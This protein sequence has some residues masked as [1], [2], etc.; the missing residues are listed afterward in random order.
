M[1]LHKRLIQTVIIF[2][3]TTIALCF[4]AF[5]MPGL[6]ITSIPAA[7][8][9]TLVLVLVESAYWWLFISFFSRMPVWLYPIVTF[10]LTGIAVYVAGNFVPGITIDDIWTGI[11]IALW[12]TVISAVLAGLFSLDADASFDRNVTR[13]LVARSGKPIE[14][15]VAGFLFLEIDG[16]SEKLL[17]RAI[18]LGYMPT[19]KKW[20]ERG[21]HT[22]TSWETDFTAQT[23]SMQPGI[24]LGKNEGIPAYRWWDRTQGRMIMSGDPRDLNVLEKQLSNGRGLLSDGGASRGNMYSGDA[25]ESMFTFSTMLDR[26]HQGGPGFYA[27]LVSPYIIARLLTRFFAEVIREWWQAWQQR[28]RNDQFQVSARNVP[29]AFFRAAMGPLL[30]D[31]TT[32]TV[33]GDIL[34]GVP[35][36]YALYAGYD[37]VGHFAGMQT[38]E[39]FEVLEET[40]R[41]IK[42]VE[43]ALQYAPRPYH[44]VVLSDHGQSEGYTFQTAY[45]VTLE[46]LVKGLT[47]QDQAVFAALDSQ[48]LW[49]NFNAFVNE[50]VNANTRTA[51]L[52]RT[53]LRSKTQTDGIVKVGPAQH[54]EQQAQAA[55]IIVLA[56]G[57]TGLIYFRGA[58]QRLTYE[59]IQARYP[60]LISGLVKHPGIGWVLVRSSEFGDIDSGAKGAYFLDK[61]EV[62]GENPLAVYGPNAVKLLKRETSFEHCPDLLINTRYDP[63]T[64]ELC[65]F[66]NQVS[67]HGGLG[68]PQNHAFI[69]HPVAFPVPAEPLVGAEQVYRLLRGWRDSVQGT[70]TERAQAVEVSP[71][72]ATVS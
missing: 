23:G 70:I 41:Y 7:L 40:D 65:G 62:E 10:V 12:M 61:D 1:P 20:L 21:S 45:G 13:K 19:L 55:E 49:D 16:L 32:Y 11:W 14:T 9:L 47:H 43:S 72:P 31:L 2:V 34:R 60:D 59:E 64:E 46:E 44:L 8:L 68:G 28:R 33:I 29:Y 25:A 38:P 35:A 18:D 69:L 58:P 39:A 30:Q 24:L 6:T 5:W 4:V 53:A 52:L 3:T 26:A 63:V 27:Y 37:D 15:D 22:V 50:S 17:R 42:R 71:T 54:D 56:S 66:E 67:H 51:A 48:E 57:S 36:V